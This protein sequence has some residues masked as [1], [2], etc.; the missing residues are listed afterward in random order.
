M[1]TDSR[2]C[3]C[4]DLGTGGPKIGVV[5]LTGHVLAK[6]FHN[7]RTNYGPRGEATQDPGEW[8]R[9]IKE[10]SQRLLSNSTV[11][12]SDIVA[13]AITGTRW[14]GLA[15][16]GLTRLTPAAGVERKERKRAKK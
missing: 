5:S 4:V 11:R 3:L 15:F 7:V 13:V 6:E 1:E 14:N 8:W 2:A 9:I 16:F 12:A 10:A